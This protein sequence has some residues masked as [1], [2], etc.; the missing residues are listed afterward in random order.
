MALILCPRCPHCS[1]QMNRVTV[2]AE[3]PVVVDMCVSHG[4]WF[5]AHELDVASDYLRARERAASEQAAQEEPAEARVEL[6]LEHFFGRGE[7]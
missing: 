1:K 7:G 2:F 5:D 6:L 4:V 3:F